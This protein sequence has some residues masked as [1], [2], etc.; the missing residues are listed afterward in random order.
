[1]EG[2]EPGRT[3]VMDLNNTR[4]MYLL[5]MYIYLKSYQEAI[6]DFEVAIKNVGYPDEALMAVKQ[7]FNERLE[8]VIQEIPNKDS[9][10]I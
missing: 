1:L 3:M 8:R 6:D 10:D 4:N 7:K 9:S 5:I 2:R